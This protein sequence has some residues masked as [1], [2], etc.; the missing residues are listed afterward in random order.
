[1]HKLYKGFSSVL[2]VMDRNL[3]M[4]FIPMM[5]KVARVW[6]LDTLQVI[7]WRQI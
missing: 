1:M 3:E 7:G 2:H 4:S 5:C 6:Y